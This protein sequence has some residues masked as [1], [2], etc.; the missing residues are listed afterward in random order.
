MKKSKSIR[1]DCRGEMSYISSVIGIAVLLLFAVL[2][3]NVFSVLTVRQ[4]MQHALDLALAL[5][6]ADGSTENIPAHYSYACQKAGIDEKE[7]TYA[8]D[9]TVYLQDEHLVAVHSDRC[10]QYGEP[11]CMQMTCRVSFLGGSLLFPSMTL[12]VQGSTLS[13]VYYK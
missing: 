13:E 5:A 6:A 1:R 2:V 10:V 7:T 9:G 12:R 4:N 3:M 11:I 8:L